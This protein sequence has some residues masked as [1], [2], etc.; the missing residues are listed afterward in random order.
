LPLSAYCALSWN[1]AEIP[2]PA[3][4]VIRL[5]AQQPPF[6]LFNYRLRNEAFGG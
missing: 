6:K 2:Y 5:R 3:L 4:D 1:F